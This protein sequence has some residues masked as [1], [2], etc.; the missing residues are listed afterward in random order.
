V[1]G[2]S[3]FALPFNGT[4][5]CSSNYG[6]DGISKNWQSTEFV[7]NYASISYFLD[8][9]TFPGTGVGAIPDGGPGCGVNGAPLD[10][11]FNVTGLTGPVESVEL[12][13]TIS[14][15]W[16]GD[17]TATLIAPDGTTSLVIFGRTGTTSA[18]G[19][20]DS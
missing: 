4:K 6:W 1:S 13:F 20:G 12:D 2:A 8:E 17:V 19:C 5:E 10:V 14:H 16:M 9:G 3:L 18:T 7:N 15:T 11:T